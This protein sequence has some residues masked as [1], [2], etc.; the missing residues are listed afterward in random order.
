MRRFSSMTRTLRCAAVLSLLAVA[1]V[2]ASVGYCEYD[3]ARDVPMP[4]EV[5]LRAGFSRASSWLFSNKERL[6]EENN[7][8]LWLFVRDAGRLSGQESMVALARDYQSR[9]T[10]RSLW[11]FVFDSSERNRVTYANIVLGDDLPDYNHLILYGATCNLMLRDDPMV[12]SLFTPTACDSGFLWLRSPWCRTHQLI[13]LRLAQMN[14]CE[15]DV[16]IAATVES[17]RKLIRREL[18]W[19]FR[20]EDAYIQKVLTLAESGPRLDLKPVWIR[21]ILN[22]Q[23]ADGGWD[24]IDIIARLP[25]G[26]VLCWAEGRLYPRIVHQPDSTLHP[27]AQA[28]YLLALLLQKGTP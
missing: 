28:L 24:G 7:P 20:V 22:A 5:E 19:D 15:A 3:N 17:V 2:I 13:G 8:M 23:R 14:H 12:R 26:R 9:Y 10:D 18:M 25:G 11:H 1:S 21:K 4:S 6:L 27:T 16:D